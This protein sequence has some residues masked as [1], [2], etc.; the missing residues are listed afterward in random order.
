M[1]TLRRPVDE[2]FEG[3]EVLTKDD[4][5]LKENR[6]GMLQYVSRLFLRVADFSRFSL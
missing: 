3:V 4:Q 5:K 2:F 6:V 1:A